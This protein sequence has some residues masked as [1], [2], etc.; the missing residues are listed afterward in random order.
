MHIMSSGWVRWHV[1]R[2]YS[3]RPTPSQFVTVYTITVLG[4]R[5]LPAENEKFRIF[6]SKNRKFLGVFGCFWEGFWVV[7]GGLGWFGVVFERF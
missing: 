3:Q 2:E 5:W 4:G 7:L 6:G 1:W